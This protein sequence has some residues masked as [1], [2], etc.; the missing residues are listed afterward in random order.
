MFVVNHDNK[1]R[2]AKAQQEWMHNEM[3]DTSFKRMNRS[4]FLNLMDDENA[5][6]QGIIPSGDIS[7]T[8]SILYDGNEMKPE[9][10]LHFSIESEGKINGEITEKEMQKLTTEYKETSWANAKHVVF[11]KSLTN[12]DKYRAKSFFQNIFSYIQ[13]RRLTI[14]MTS[15]DKWN[16]NI[17]SCTP[18]LSVL[19]F[20]FVSGLFNPLSPIQIIILSSSFS[21]SIL[22]RFNTYTS[23]P[24]GSPIPSLMVFHAF[25]MS[26]VWI[27]TFA[28]IVVDLITIYG[29]IMGVSSTILAVTLLA[30]GNCVGDAMASY[31][32]AKKGYGGMAM[33][34]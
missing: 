7:G 4:E 21:L 20:L 11:K 9:E 1:E 25:I 24:P 28:N 13:F 27:W 5:Y 16:R 12:A 17:D 26:I 30:I 10:L 15:S 33:T 34:G 8:S 31:S 19:F 22:M 6:N 18:F 3:K 29:D 2:A 32:I 14:P 23:E